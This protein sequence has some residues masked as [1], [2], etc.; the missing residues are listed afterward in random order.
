MLYR[1]CR[2]Y[3][4]IVEKSG[5]FFLFWFFCLFVRRRCCRIYTV[6]ERRRDDET[7][8]GTLILRKV[9]VFSYESR[10]SVSIFLH[11]PRVV[12]LLFSLIFFFISENS[13]LN[14]Y[15]SNRSPVVVSDNGCRVEKNRYISFFFFVK[16]RVTRVTEDECDTTTILLFEIM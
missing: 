8:T 15:I 9:F 6:C 1:L 2:L 4:I 3:I 14:G 10:K 7:K 16:Y 12:V 5:V 13:T 11:S